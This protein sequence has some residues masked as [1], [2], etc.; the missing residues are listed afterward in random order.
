MW[1]LAAVGVLVLGTNRGLFENL[2][3]G[4]RRLIVCLMQF[5]WVLDWKLKLLHRS[6]FSPRP[7]GFLV[8]SLCYLMT[9]NCSSQYW[10]T[11]MSECLT[12]SFPQHIFPGIGLNSLVSVEDGED[13]RDE[14][15]LQCGSYQGGQRSVILLLRSPG[16]G[17]D[18]LLRQWN[19]E[20]TSPQQ[21]VNMNVLL[22][23]FFIQSL[24]NCYSQR[25][26]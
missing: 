7:A 18:W 13:A 25:A 14:R 5:L 8:I 21:F 22:L 19:I 11:S 2:R 26:L 16:G 3:R 9:R 10:P 17:S 23:I 1:I 15:S 6:V 12:H 4:E 20:Q 24:P